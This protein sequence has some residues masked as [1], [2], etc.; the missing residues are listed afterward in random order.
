MSVNLK[1]NLKLYSCNANT[2]WELSTPLNSYRF[3][4]DIFFSTQKLVLN[5][6]SNFACEHRKPKPGFEPTTLCPSAWQTIGQTTNQHR[7]EGRLPAMRRVY[8]DDHDNQHLS[9]AESYLSF[10][11]INIW[12]VT[13]HYLI[14]AAT[15][16]I[17]K[18]AYQEWAD[19]VE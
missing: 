16:Y 14:K 3:P 5:S 1:Q 12:N 6:K 19:N 17:T 18:H 4:Q 2:D 7:S 8:D 13:C 11:F 10:V 15:V 9:R